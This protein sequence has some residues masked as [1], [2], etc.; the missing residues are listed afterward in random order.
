MSVL[1][2]NIPRYPPFVKGLPVVDP[3]KLLGA[4][5]ELVN[6]IAT[7]VLTNKELYEKHYLGA[8]RRFAA[9]AHLLPASQMHH[10]RGAGGLLRHSLEVGLW[11]LQASDKMLLDIAK[12]PKQRRELEPRWQLTAFL[13]GLCHD[14]GKPATDLVVSSLDRSIVWKPIKENLWDWAQSSGVDAYFLDWRQG[15][16]K[17]HI[18]LSNLI[19]DRIIST[20]TLTWIQE[21]GTELIVWLMESLNGN[22]GTINPLYD[23]VLKAD[24]SST[25][26]DLKSMGVAMA[27]YDLGVPVERHLTDIMRRFVKQGIWSVNELG[28]RIWNIGGHIYLVWPT[29]GDDIG[30]QVKEDGV[31][32]IPRTAE[33]ILEMLVE[34]QM[35]SVKPDVDGTGRFW[36]IVPAVLA[37]K[38]PNKSFTCIRLRDD[39]MVSSIPIVPI[40]GT[41]LSGED[42]AVEPAPAP[43][44]KSPK[45]AGASA[46]AAAVGNASAPAERAPAPEKSRP[47]AIT[48]SVPEQESPTPG[49]PAA[50]SGS[51][52]VGYS[53]DRETGEI[54]TPLDDAGHP[55][56][57]P[58]AIAKNSGE[59]GGGS[60][61]PSTATSSPSP[62]Q[63]PEAAL[64]PAKPKRQVPPTV[65]FDGPCGEAMKALADDLKSGVKLWGSD[66][67]VESEESVLLTWP[68]AFAG[69]GLTVKTI[70]DELSAKE[71]LWVDQ[72]SPLKRVLDFEEDGQTFKVIRL[73]AEASYALVHAAGYTGK[74]KTTKPRA[75]AATAQAQQ[76]TSPPAATGGDSTAKPSSAPIAP[77]PAPAPVSPQSNPPPKGQPTQHTKSVPA[78]SSTAGEQRSLE[79]GQVE[80]HGTPPVL[81]QVASPPAQTADQRP[82]KP[83]KTKPGQSMPSLTPAAVGGASPSAQEATPTK[84]LPS[85]SELAGADSPAQRTPSLT[86]TS[87]LKSIKVPRPGGE[88]PTLEEVLAALQGKG[89][90]ADSP[91]WNSLLLQQA[92]VAFKEAGLAIERSHLYKLSTSHTDVLTIAKGMVLYRVAGA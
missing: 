69:Y 3:D 76:V 43:V 31:P 44:A 5:Q 16:S 79:L 41:I 15:R 78:R 75:P 1:D 55:L 49:A 83:K 60:L 86:A 14:A 7:G 51:S 4:Q 40:E 27:G 20:E 33:G 12:T 53:F 6:Q 34:R 61:P 92:N 22:P 32:G 77:R 85:A 24:Q 71:W 66:V 89:V 10:H 64:Q 26:R 87:S 2:E 62:T 39:A 28:A 59:M 88:A 81:P 67:R 90:A 72:M 18:A 65:V 9:Y 35:A 74:E 25:E 45:P 56:Q 23:L 70:L 54:T 48:A 91:G 80:N 13:A 57:A 52:S 17:Q 8:M 82:L 38:I 19:A 58:N 46:S 21:G 63:P 42:G 11:A 29:S 37:A 47:L 30:R 73:E 68:T 50:D 36:R 84:S